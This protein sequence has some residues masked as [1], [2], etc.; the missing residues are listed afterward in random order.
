MNKRNI[1]ISLVL[2][3]L[4]ITSFL[5]YSFVPSSYSVSE[6]FEYLKNPGSGYIKVHELGDIKIEFVYVPAEEEA[7]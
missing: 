2:L 3:G 7:L 1:K 4:T 6:Y 5:V